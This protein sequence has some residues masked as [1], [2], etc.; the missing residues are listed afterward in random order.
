MTA[1]EPVNII[2]TLPLHVEDFLHLNDSGAFE[3]YGK[4]ELIDGGIVYINAQH[5]PHARIKSDLFVI[6]RGRSR[7]HRRA[8]DG[9]DRGNREHAAT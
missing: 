8:F 9:V 5:R 2:R 3:G 6:L 7:G 1:A 4:T